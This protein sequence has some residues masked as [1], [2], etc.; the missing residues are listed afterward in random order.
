[1][2]YINTLMNGEQGLFKQHLLTPMQKM[3]LRFVVVGLLYYGLAVIEGMIMRM[4]E[5]TP[6]FN[7]HA[8]VFCNTNRTS[9]CWNFWFDIFNCFWCVSFSCSFLMK[10]PLWSIKMAN[11]TCGV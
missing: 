11:W 2:S 7:Y 6:I 1:M 3:T 10:K 5:V 8:P 4:Y 9:A